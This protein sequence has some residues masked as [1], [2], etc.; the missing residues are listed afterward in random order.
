MKDIFYSLKTKDKSTKLICTQI[1]EI[2]SN[3]CKV[4]C[5]DYEGGGFWIVTSE[6][7]MKLKEKLEKLLGIELGDPRY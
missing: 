7:P 4:I 3:K 6:D 5:D 2:P 1:N